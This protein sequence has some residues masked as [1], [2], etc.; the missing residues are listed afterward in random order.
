MNSTVSYYRKGELVCL[1]LD[2]ELAA[3]TGGRVTLDHVLRHLWE[4]YGVG[5]RPVPEDA[6]QSIFERVAGVPLGDVF[7][8]WIRRPGELDFAPALARVGVDVERSSSRLDAPAGSLGVRL[9]SE[10]ARTPS[11][12]ASV[13]RDSAAWRAGIDPGDE[14]VG[15]A[16]QR[17]D[18]TNLEAALRGKGPG[19]SVDVVVARDGKLLTRVATL[20]PPRLDRVKLAI[21]PDA[22]P[23]ARAAFQAWLGQLPPVWEKAKSP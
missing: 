16:G 2:L 11:V 6:L 9:R 22:A 1:L 18:G 3:R 7:D 5:E 10:G 4:E 19:E 21:Q 12:V 23:A 15:V 17:T 14:I 8:A 13:M 20:D